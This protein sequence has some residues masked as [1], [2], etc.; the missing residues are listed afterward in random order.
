MSKRILTIGKIENELIMDV[1]S[2]PSYGE[3]SGG[4]GYTFTVGGRSAIAAKTF[5][6]FGADSVICARLGNDE[7][8]ARIT[9]LFDDVGIDTRFMTHDSSL[10]T[11]FTATMKE[12]NGRTR[13]IHYEGANSHFG[14]EELENAFLCYPDALFFQFELP[15]RDLVAASRLAKRQDIP[16]FVDAG[17]VKFDLPLEYLENVE[18][19]FLDEHEIE[20]FTGVFPGDPDRCLRASSLL[21]SKLDAKYIV[22][23]LGNRGSFVYDGTYYYVITPYETTLIDKSGVGDV[24]S[25]VVTYEYLKDRDIKRACAVGSLAAALTVSKKG[26]YESVPTLAEIRSFAERIGVEVGAL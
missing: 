11:A 15:A 14:R 23:K 19:F 1:D 17:P 22:L 21:A 9:T 2:I 6:T 13:A 20:E 18:I 24:F 8:A 25:S 16:V 5:K 10:P 26:A 3:V 4:E 12:K 7:N